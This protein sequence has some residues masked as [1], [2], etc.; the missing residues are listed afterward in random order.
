MDFILDSAGRLSF[1]FPTKS[2][3]F[4]Y[5]RRVWP[6]VLNPFP[7]HFP[8]LRWPPPPRDSCDHTPGRLPLFPSLHF[9]L[10]AEV[11]WGRSSSTPPS[12]SV[13]PGHSSW[14]PDLWGCR[15]DR[16]DSGPLRDETDWKSCTK[17][18]LYFSYFIILHSKDRRYPLFCTLYYHYLARY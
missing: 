7:V 4:S 13:L 17:D 15:S 1:F 11:P 6:R 10:S 18:T 9:P 12:A 16:T 14:R 5:W 3:E 8:Y 2:S